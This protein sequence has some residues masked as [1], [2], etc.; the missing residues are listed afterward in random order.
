MKWRYKIGFLLILSLIGWIIYLCLASY[1]PLTSEEI[2]KRVTY[3]ERVV[4][5]PLEEGSEVLKLRSE[6]SEFMLF[7]YAYSTYALTNLAMQDSSYSSRAVSLIRESIVKVLD[8]QVSGVYGIDR[9]AQ[10]EEMYRNGSVLYLGHLNLML[11]CYRLLCA[12]GQYNTLNDEISAS[13]VERYN[14]CPFLN[15][16]SYP[17]QIWIP[18]NTVALASL[19]LHSYNANNDYDTLCVKWVEYAKEHYLEE[20]TS[21]LYSTIDSKTGRVKEEPRGSMLGWS[22]MFIYQFD[23]EFASA[24]YSNY[25]KYF[26]TNYGVL[27]LF[28][29]RSDSYMTSIGDI[30]SGPI[31]F[32]FSI[33][34]NEFALGGAMMEEDYETVTKVNRLIGIGAKKLDDGVEIRYK[35]RLWDMNISPM[36]EAL[37]LN[38]LTMRRWVE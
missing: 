14:T 3:L 30:D 15:L 12:D 38:S 11:G 5:E 28:R 10:K 32:G 35:V 21:V 13:L 31:V 18:D 2:D 36:A 4:Q 25:K 27:R 23:D 9:D 22:I 29:E 24:L 8:S 7:T 37:V 16:E 26:S 33:P 34:A 20:Q 6:S 19:K 1:V 17:S